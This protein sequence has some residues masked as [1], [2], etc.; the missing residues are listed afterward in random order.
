MRFSGVCAKRGQGTLQAFFFF[1][2]FSF[3]SFFPLFLFFSTSFCLPSL[4]NPTCRGSHSV[5]P[6]KIF[7]LRA[8]KA[9]P[10]PEHLLP[11]CCDWA[12]KRT[13]VLKGG[14]L[15]TAHFRIYRLRGAGQWGWKGNY[16]QHFRKV[17]LG[18]AGR[19]SSKHILCCLEGSEIPPVMRGTVPAPTP[20]P[21]APYSC[22]HAPWRK[23]VLPLVP[24]H[25]LLPGQDT[26]TTL[27]TALCGPPQTG[28]WGAEGTSLHL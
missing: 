24:G 8:W 15:R 5:P 2:L 7:I 26:A 19:S 28:S 21:A 23:T 22:L 9:S 13:E 12:M 14:Y 25:V 18:R 27:W 1:F 11:A 4:S 16:M 20:C 10:Y 6:P 17:K 3:S